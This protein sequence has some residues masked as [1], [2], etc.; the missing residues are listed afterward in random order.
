[1]HTV[2]YINSR[3]FVILEMSSLSII[4]AVGCACLID[5]VSTGAVSVQLG[6]LRMERVTFGPITHSS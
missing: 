1:M 5:T 2:I 3:R 6:N 4:P